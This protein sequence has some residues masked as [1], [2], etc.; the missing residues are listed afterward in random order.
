MSRSKNNRSGREAAIETAELRRNEARRAER[1]AHERAKDTGDA[2]DQRAYI[3]AAWKAQRAERSFVKATTPR[4]TGWV[5]LPTRHGPRYHR[6]IGTDMQLDV[7]MQVVSWVASAVVNNVLCSV[8]L[9]RPS[10]ESAAEEIENM[11][12]IK[13]LPLPEGDAE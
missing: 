8:V 5:M 7:E 12:G 6:E 11:R 13:H 9:N 3:E 1:L 2:D 10:A 4:D